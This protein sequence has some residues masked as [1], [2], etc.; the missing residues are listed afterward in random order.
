M[1]GAG[2]THGP[3]VVEECMQQ[4]GNAS[5]LARIVARTRGVREK[6]RDIVTQGHRLWS[7]NTT[8]SRLVEELYAHTGKATRVERL[9]GVRRALCHH[10]REEIY[11]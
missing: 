1:Q 10:N 4:S 6:Q 5:L 2:T 3:K 11:R 8:A 9:T 7:D